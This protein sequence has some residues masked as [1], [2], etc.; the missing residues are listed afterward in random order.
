MAAAREAETETE[1]ESGGVWRVR[2]KCRWWS[3]NRGDSCVGGISVS[4]ALPIATRYTDV[5]RVGPT[6][7]GPYCSRVGGGGCEFPG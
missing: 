6:W 1:T 3:G 2:V 4:E 7:K 5:A